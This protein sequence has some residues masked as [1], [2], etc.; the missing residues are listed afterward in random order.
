MEKGVSK[1]QAISVSMPQGYSGA[2]LGGWAHYR[3]SDSRRQTPDGRPLGW[4]FPGL[5]VRARDRGTAAQPIAGDDVRGWMAEAAA[6][7]SLEHRRRRRRSVEE[8]R[9]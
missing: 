8:C 2:A 5:A 7:A 3:R 9:G 6:V 1:D 4:Q